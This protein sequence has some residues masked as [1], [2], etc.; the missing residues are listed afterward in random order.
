MQVL[1]CIA[2]NIFS[3]NPRVQTQ[4]HHWKVKSLK[5]RLLNAIAL[6]CGLQ[7]RKMRRRKKTGSCLFP[8]E[9][10]CGRPSAFR[11]ELFQLSFAEAVFRGPD[12]MQ[13]TL[14]HILFFEGGM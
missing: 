4:G 1:Q 12:P 6:A 9:S 14:K 7:S 13:S 2:Y 10:R 8:R 11:F 3:E 5:G